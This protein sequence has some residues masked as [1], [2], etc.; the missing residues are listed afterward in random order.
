MQ[1]IDLPNAGSLRKSQ[2]LKQLPRNVSKELRSKNSTVKMNEDGG[3][4]YE[5]STKDLGKFFPDDGI[6]RV[7]Q[8]PPMVKGDSQEHIDKMLSKYK[9]PIKKQQVILK[10][11]KLKLP[12]VVDSVDVEEFDDVIYDS[13]KEAKKAMAK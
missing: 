6:I 1:D 8:A 11:N 10:P 12:K 3:I 9:A 5:G 2:H 7:K 4:L 13:D